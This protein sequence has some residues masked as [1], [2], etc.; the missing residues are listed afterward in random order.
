MLGWGILLALLPVAT[1]QRMIGLDLCG[2]QPATYEFTFDFDQICDDSNVVG[3]GINETACL[4]EIRG[5]D[6]VPD[7]ELIPASV[8]SVQIFELDQLQQ[9]RVEISFGGVANSLAVF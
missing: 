7:V 8:Q 5:R 1:G 4:T 2:C 3:P 6:E 9:V